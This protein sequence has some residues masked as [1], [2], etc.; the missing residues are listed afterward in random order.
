MNSS[1][2]FRPCAL[3]ACPCKW[4]PLL[5]PF[6][7]Y[8]LANPMLHLLNPPRL[9]RVTASD[10]PLLR[11]SPTEGSRGPDGQRAV[12]SEKAPRNRRG[13]EGWLQAASQPTR[14]R[15]PRSKS[16]AVPDPIT[17]SN[18]LAAPSRL[19]H[20]LTNFRRDRKDLEILEES[21]MGLDTLIIAVR[22]NPHVGFVVG[23]RRR[24]SMTTSLGSSGGGCCWWFEE[25]DGG[26]KTWVN[27]RRRVRVMTRKWVHLKSCQHLTEN[28]KEKLTEV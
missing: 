22:A 16:I 8:E 10:Q 21:R 12:E 5:P 27:W 28:F 26:G 24:R 23:L 14:A 4:L 3:E 25:E 9:D 18:K 19:K 20:Y 15:R 6:E 17:A 7:N 11:P 1:R 2:A 13:L